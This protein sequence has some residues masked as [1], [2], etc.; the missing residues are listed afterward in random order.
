MGTRFKKYR[1]CVAH[2]DAVPPKRGTR[3]YWKVEEPMNRIVR[4]RQIVFAMLLAVAIGG[5]SYILWNQTGDRVQIPADRL[6]IIV[7]QNFGGRMWGTD[8]DSTLL[9]CTS[10]EFRSVI[11]RR[12][13][14]ALAASPV[15]PRFYHIV[16]LPDYD[17]IHR[18]ISLATKTRLEPEIQS[19]TLAVLEIKDV[20][21]QQ[22]TRWVVTVR[23]IPS[24]AR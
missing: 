21:T 6:A 15:D 5:L 4:P 11:D 2:S 12:V 16:L 1:V 19:E 22:S 9:A 17:A 23:T 10:E 24:R 13:Q 3:L 7:G 8:A 20:L 18:F 14:D